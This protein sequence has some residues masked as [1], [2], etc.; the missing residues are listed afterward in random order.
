M[1]SRTFCGIA[2]ARRPIRLDALEREQ[3]DDLADEE[4]VAFGLLVQRAR[5]LRR[6]DRRAVR[7]RYGDRDSRPPSASATVPG[8]RATSASIS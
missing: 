7:S 4:R 5:Q 2:A 6:R 1:T 8:S 3:P